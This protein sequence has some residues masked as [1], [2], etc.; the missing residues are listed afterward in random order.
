MPDPKKKAKQ[1]MKKSESLKKMAAQQES[2]GKGQIKNKVK[3]GSMQYNGNKLPVG[4]QRLDIA[5][6]MRSEAS[7]DSLK[8]VKMY[9]SITP[10]KK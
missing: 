6:K 4:K 7:S 2:L 10:K 3:E 1:L 8:A 5:K 9:P